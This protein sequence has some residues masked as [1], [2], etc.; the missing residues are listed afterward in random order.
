MVK[1]GKDIK[2]NSKNNETKPKEHKQK[3][4]TE[5][6][7]PPKQ[8]EKSQDQIPLKKKIKKEPKY[9]DILETQSKNVVSKKTKKQGKIENIKKSKPIKQSE[10]KKKEVQEKTNV[11]N[12]NFESINNYHLYIT[13]KL[14][15]IDKLK[16]KVLKK[17]QLD[18]KLI[19]KAVKVLLDHNEKTK[20]PKNILDTNEGFIYVE[21]SFNKLPEHYSVRPIQ[22][23]F[24]LYKI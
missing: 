20:N 17:V 19:L 7:P 1:K 24:L 8:K 11:S 18:K 10:N 9:K 13:E 3:K 21:I 2:K 22:M 12:E 23:Y 14:S 4:A 15:K 16:E 5:S 6:N